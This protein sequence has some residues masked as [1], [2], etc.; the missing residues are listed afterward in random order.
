MKKQERV[1]ALS[2]H[3][4][5][6]AVALPQCGSSGFPRSPSLLVESGPNARLVPDSAI[7]VV[8]LR[9]SLKFRLNYGELLTGARCSPLSSPLPDPSHSSPASNGFTC[10]PIVPH[11]GKVPQ[12]MLTCECPFGL[13]GNC[14]F[15]FSTLQYVIPFGAVTV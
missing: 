2:V 5:W 14:I 15:S 7:V 13:T 6:S 11:K 8:F 3:S 12:K 1:S 4:S 10:D 9:G